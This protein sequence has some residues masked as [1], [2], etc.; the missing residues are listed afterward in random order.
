MKFL[1][2]KMYCLSVCFAILLLFFVPPM[3][4]AVLL[5]TSS[6]SYTAHSWQPQNGL[7]GETVQA[8]A[9]TGDGYLWIGTNEGLARFDGERFTL[10]TR[11]NTPAL[12]ESSVFCL[13]VDH[14]GALWI[15]TEGG[16]LVRYA[17]GLFRRYTA[18][19]GLSDGFVRSLFEDHAGALWVAT[20]NGL[21]R[22]NDEQ[23]TRIDNRPAMPANAFHA[24]LEDHRGRIWAGAPRLYALIN[25]QPHEFAL[26]GTDSQNRVKSILETTDGSIWVG[27]VSGLHRLP[28]GALRFERVRGVQ[29]T[30]R[31][32]CAVVNGELWAGAIGQGIFRVHY[33]EHET[34]VTH[35]AAPSPDVSNTTL[36]IFEDSAQ[37]LWVGTQVGMARLSRTPVRVVPLPEAADSDFGTVSLDADGSVWAAS[38]QLVHVVGE[39]ARPH[40][41][42]ALND[43]RVRNLL[44]SRDGA[45]W[46]GTDGSGL[47]RIGAHG[48]A[49]YTMQQGLANNFI[50][51]MIEA[52]DGSLWIGMDEGV[53]HFNGT[54]FRN[55]TMRNGLAYF[56]TRALLE[57][58][59]G[60]IWIGTERGLTHLH[61]SQSVRD[62]ATEALRDE[63]IWALH[64]DAD[65][66]LWIGTRSNGLYRYRNGA[67]SHYTT[68]N[69][70]ASNSIYSILE[71][72]RRHMWISGPAGVMLLNRDELDAQAT[73]THRTLSVH[74]YRGD[75]GDQP[76]LFYGGTQPAGVLTREDDAWF[77]TNRGLWHIRATDF[78]AP[79]LE[80]LHIGMVKVDGRTVSSA[81]SLHLSAASTRIEIAF[82]PVMLGSQENLAFRYRLEGFDRDWS[83]ASETQ[84]SAT[85]T[86]L[87]AGHYNFILEAWQR[88]DP[89]Q[90]MQ[91][92]LAIDKQPYFY[93]TFWFIGGCILLTALLTVFAYRM[94]M[95]QV[96]ARYRAVLDERTRLA[97]EMH[98]TLIQ[99]CASVS[100]MLEAASSEEIGD[101]DSRR[102]LIEY[103]ST[104]IRAT[105][106]EARQAVWNLREGEA[107]ARSLSDCLLQMAERLEREAS[108]SVRL[109]AEGPPI[110]LAQTV[111][112][113]LTMVAREAIYNAVLHGAAQTIDLELLFETNRI[114][115]V[116]HDD[117]S[118]FNSAAHSPD[119]HY[120]LQGMRER[121]A[122]LGGKVEIESQQL[123]GTIIR[124]VLPHKRLRH[125]QA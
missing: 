71:D 80:H 123:S 67:L 88:E 55:I 36:S 9:Q 70:L 76:T 24:V 104:Q 3:T 56:S 38:N 61:Q 108:V 113:E 47:F 53:S 48:V 16:G 65:G 45:L 25:G 120:G 4:R 39:Q 22:K 31:T 28:P 8:F 52:R 35:Q 13:L 58:R 96:H 44:R 85:Y 100:A 106:D 20:D 40:R 105:M 1:F 82:E 21:F 23:F 97:R 102:H 125:E 64:E 75:A 12:H 27:T 68:A 99:G 62:Q 29:G 94:R 73:D 83:V 60:D 92:R 2:S 49:H 79:P 110:A 5:A 37:S 74:F 51:C 121:V 107:I 7:P 42:A 15:G 66:G 111:I 6:D 114:V 115:L 122:R 11:E 124:V 10:F 50:R 86:N 103:A 87:P 33:G 69:G 14:G 77:P 30:I 43:A 101:E 32:L 98:D 89:G 59:A 78:G 84:R 26:D 112:H 116:V 117:G 63:K 57:D 54:I 91:A 95:R 119:G 46:I 118:G 72:S 34:V 18:S 109:R 17:R 41:F 90:R 19:D 93:R 81:S